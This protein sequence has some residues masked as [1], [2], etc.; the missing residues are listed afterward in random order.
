MKIDYYNV[1]FNERGVL[2]EPNGYIDGVKLFSRLKNSLPKLILEE[3][4]LSNLEK[5]KLITRERLWGVAPCVQKEFEEWEEDCIRIE[6]EWATANGDLHSSKIV[7]TFL[8]GYKE[9]STVYYVDVIHDILECVDGDETA[10]FELI[11]NRGTYHSTV[12]KPVNE[13]IDRICKYAFENEMIGFVV[14]Y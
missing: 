6:R 14:D 5:L 10:E 4:T 13:I 2:T 11:R 1:K 3:S 9:Y 8:D 12:S 7:D